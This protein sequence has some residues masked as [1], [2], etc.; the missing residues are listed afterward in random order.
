MSIHNNPS[1]D[2]ERELLRKELGTFSGA[3]LAGGALTSVFTGEKVNDYDLYFRSHKDFARAVQ[4][5]Y[6]EYNHWC[7]S[8]TR[9]A[10]TFKSHDTVYQFMFFR[11]FET[12]EEIFK[13]FD[14]T[15]CMAALDAEEGG[16]FHLHPRFLVDASQRKLVFNHETD[17][18][19]ASAVR[20]MK[21]QERGYTITR[22]EWLK[23]LAACVFRDVKDWGDLEDQIGGH[24]GD[25]VASFAKDKDKPFTLESV[26]AALERRDLASNRGEE[27]PPTNYEDAIKRISAIRR[28]E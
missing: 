17:F 21:Y 13:S 15:C 14:F 6:E 26:V 1:Y 11:F 18:P 19:I 7:V 4:E 9:R 12:P 16:D 28:L 24:Y 5:A 10:I 8:L 22:S 20:I 3:F 23:V 2:Q 27:E 25:I